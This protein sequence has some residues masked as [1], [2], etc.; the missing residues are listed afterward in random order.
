[1]TKKELREQYFNKRNALSDEYRKDADRIIFQKLILTDEFT[2]SDLILVYVSVGAEIDTSAIIDYAFKH[3]KSVAVPYCSKGRMDFYIIN[4]TDELVCKQF[5]IPVVDITG[6]NSVVVTEKTL[7]IVP[8]LCV[9]KNNNRLGYGGGYYDK[10]LSE[11]RVNN[12]CLVRKDF[13]VD[14]I[15]AEIFDYKIAKLLSDN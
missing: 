8:A 2:E 7:C 11:N 15:G 4:S 3:G 6:R 5:G 9:D 13:I 10:F 14:D 1:M 12:I